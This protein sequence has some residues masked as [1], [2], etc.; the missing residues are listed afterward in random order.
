V[1]E[2]ARAFGL[3]AGQYERGRPGYPAP[4][5][6]WL[7]GSRPL[8]VVDLGAG[9][10][11]LTEAL[12]EA[13]HRVVAVEPL[14]EMRERLA[15]AL[16][17]VSIVDATAEDT[18]LPGA[19]ADAVVAGA[20]FHWFDTARAFPEI[21]RILRPPGILGLLGNGFDAESQA[22][23]GRL[24][25]MVR[26]QRGSGRRR[27]PETAELLE[28]FD[29][30]EDWTF[31]H[32]QAVSRSSLAD[33]AQSYSRVAVLPELDR[34]RLLDRLARFWDDDPDLSGCETAMLSWRTTVRRCRG[35]R[36]RG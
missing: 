6:A 2:R 28:W 1:V 27:W 24:A 35:I 29:E 32:E 4:A 26:S 14:A 15:A 12:V 16:P 10:G 34:Q 5:I 25:E 22:W 20:A 21:A 23:V 36:R 3:V 33:L 9:T 19:S 30:V 13:G 17:A 11:K 18:T 8:D 7:L 31:S